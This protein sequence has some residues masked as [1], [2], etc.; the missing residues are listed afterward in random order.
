M[1]NDQKSDAKQLLKDI[2]S[3]EQ[4]KNARQDLSKIDMK[5]NKTMRLAMRLGVEILAALAMSVFI[6]LLIDHFFDTY[7][8]GF[9][10]MFVFGA[11]AGVWNVYK[12]LGFHNKNNSGINEE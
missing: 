12:V 7:P 4:K 5:S 10:I 9:I 1:P 2:E 3:A 6:G 11:F 8:I